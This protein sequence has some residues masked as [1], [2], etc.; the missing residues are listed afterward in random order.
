MNRIVSNLFLKVSIFDKGLNKKRFS[1]EFLVEPGYFVRL[2]Q[3]NNEQKKRKAGTESP[4]AEKP[5]K[6]K[7]LK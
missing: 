1:S 5:N 3:M 6:S 7:Y 4:I 2:H